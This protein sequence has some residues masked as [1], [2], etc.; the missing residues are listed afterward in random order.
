MTK[1]LHLPILLAS[2]LSL[3]PA[4]LE[5][6]PQPSPFG[7]DSG[8]FIPDSREPSLTDLI[9]SDVVVK[10][11]A[12]E[13]DMKADHD[14]IGGLD[15]MEVLPADQVPED[16]PGDVADLH[17]D[18]LDGVTPEETLDADAGPDTDVEVPP[19]P[20]N[21]QLYPADWTPA[22]T[23]AQGRFLPDFSY[24]G[25]HNSQTEVPP[26][27]EGTLFDIL[28]YS[29]DPTGLMDSTA[30]IQAAIDAAVTAGGGIVTV[31]AGLYRVDGLLQITGSHIILRGEGPTSSRLLFT[32]V[33]NMAH[34]SHLTFR[35][36]VTTKG[37]WPLV[38][39]GQNRATTLLLDDASQLTPGDD[40][41]VGWVITPEFIEEHGMTGTWQA[42][43][44]SWQP[45]FRRQVVAVDTA[46]TP[47]VVTLDVP[48]R[49][50]A[51]MRD[52]ATLRKETGYLQE[53]G[54]EHLGIA[55]A[56]T[57]EQA[58]SQERSNAVTFQGVKDAWIVD[59]ASFPSPL[60]PAEDPSAG[61]HLQGGGLKVLASKRVTVAHC[62]LERA[63]NRG[64]GGSGYLFEISQS[65]EVLTRDCVGRAG[66]HNFI[67]NWGFGTT[68]CVWLRCLSEQ[69][70]AVPLKDFP[71][72]GTIG[73]SE[74]HHSLATANLIQQCTL[75]DGWKAVNRQ[76]WSTGAG[77]TATQ[78]VFWNNGGQGSLFSRQ[79]G[80]GYVIGTS[81][82]LDVVTGLTGLG[83]DEAEGS[84]P[85]DYTEG[86]GLG[87][88][89]LPADLF[90]DQLQ[91]RLETLPPVAPQ[92]SEKP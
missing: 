69:G 84:Q 18:D 58:W 19:Q 49:Y 12:P 21:S 90:L 25:Y 77:L 53:V 54:M 20:W 45:F 44:G 46:V 63:Q 52:Q 70:L 50:P 40:V 87:A 75:N 1:A 43:N 3:L 17:A 7:D 24:A 5:S 14:T 13:E 80:W 86:L 89:L 59:V 30:A 82:E 6:N 9:A 35:G 64:D 56:V 55:S 15:L 28:S 32:R 81:P 34:N 85:E 36:T 83:A 68:G 33:E 76:Q 67:Q 11:L 48:L 60:V 71:A 39:D 41:S 51:L 38:A 66:R 47:N 79:F 88:Q 91:R 8:A 72:I 10:D 57:W 16:V 37:E 22:F 4:C 31:P 29:A 78:N 62:T 65:S 61:A 2:L 42:F 23:D 26:A 74:F 27:A 73:Y 92:R